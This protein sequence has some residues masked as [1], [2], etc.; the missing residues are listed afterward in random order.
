MTNPLLVG[1]SLGVVGN[2]ELIPG[3]TEWTG[4]QSVT[5]QAQRDRPS[6]TLAHTYGQFRV[7]FKVVFFPDIQFKKIPEVAE[8]DNVEKNLN[9]Y[10]PKGD[11]NRQLDDF[12]GCLEPY[13]SQGGPRKLL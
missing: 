4:L 13:G 2:L 11:D 10:Q 6:L 7:G 1:Y 5:R 12:K 3:D 8:R 9:R